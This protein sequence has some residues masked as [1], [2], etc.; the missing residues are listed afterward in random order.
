MYRTKEKISLPDGRFVYKFFLVVK[1]TNKMFIAYAQTIKEGKKILQ[2]ELKRLKIP[3][4]LVVRDKADAADL[5]IVN[6]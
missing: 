3:K 6:I 5:F 2:D 1:G 4:E